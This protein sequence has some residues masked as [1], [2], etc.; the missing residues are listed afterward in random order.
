MRALLT[1]AVYFTPFLLIG[2]V[3][4]IWMQRKGV[5]LRDVQTEGDPQRPRRSRFLLGV[6]RNVGSE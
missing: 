1:L 2:V 5:E 3:A 6:W 4:K